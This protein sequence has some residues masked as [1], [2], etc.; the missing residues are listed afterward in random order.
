MSR[1]RGV[2]E[3]IFIHTSWLLLRNDFFRLRLTGSPTWSMFAW[4]PTD[5]GLPEWF[6]LF[7]LFKFR[8]PTIPC[9][10]NF[11]RIIFKWIIFFLGTF[12]HPKYVRK[13]LWTYPNDSYLKYFQLHKSSS[14]LFKPLW[15]YWLLNTASFM[16]ISRKEKWTKLGSFIKFRHNATRKS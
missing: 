3:P 11:F 8:L 15:F 6:S 2:C 14:Q 13:C 7:S 4:I 9:S 12:L 5:L 10:L 1:L 16:S